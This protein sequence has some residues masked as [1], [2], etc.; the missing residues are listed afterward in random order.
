MKRAASYLAVIVLTVLVCLAVIPSRGY[1]GACEYVC[2]TVT[3]TR[4]T[5]S[6]PTVTPTALPASARQGVIFTGPGSVDNGNDYIARLNSG[7]WYNYSAILWAHTTTGVPM[8]HAVNDYALSIAAQYVPVGSYYLV[9]NEPD[10]SDQ[11]NISPTTG[12]QQYY[13]IR[14]R[15]L[16]TD[17][18]A[19]FIVGGMSNLGTDLAAS[20]MGTQGGL[21]WIAQMKTAYQAAYGGT[22]PADGYHAHLYLCGRDYSSYTYQH[23]IIN[24]HDALAANGLTGQFWL[25]ETGCLNNTASAALIMA[26]NLDWLRTTP[27]LDRFAWFTSYF[28][29]GSGSLLDGYGAKTLLGTQYAQ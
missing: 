18:T 20:P 4:A 1:G 12:A 10:R 28:T 8:L 27:Y 16:A 26:E 13:R 23:S 7:W 17:P 24:F 3:P 11:D 14:Q 6:T 5:T 9:Y 25:T 2:V 29:W 21:A 15:I 22:M 19:R